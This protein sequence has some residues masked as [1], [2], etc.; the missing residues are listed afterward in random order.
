MAKHKP[1]L[2]SVVLLPAEALSP[3]CAELQ[4]RSC[5]LEQL[6]KAAGFLCAGCC[7]LGCAWHPPPWHPSVGCPQ[8]IPWLGGSLG[9]PAGSTGYQQEVCVS[10]ALLG[11]CPKNL[12]KQCLV[13]KN[14]CGSPLLG[15]IYVICLK[16]TH[17]N[18]T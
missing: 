1:Q 6:D 16:N 7:Q 15:N 12:G 14:R 11:N 18:P 8:S 5:N 9:V 4:H 13:L 3:F 17:K 2:K 10:I